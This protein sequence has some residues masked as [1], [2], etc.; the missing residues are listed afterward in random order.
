[1]QESTYPIRFI[2]KKKPIKDVDIEVDIIN[3]AEGLKVVRSGTDKELHWRVGGV[4][5]EELALKMRNELEMGSDVYVIPA[6]RTRS[7]RDK[8]YNL[9][10]MNHPFEEST[11]PSFKRF[12]SEATPD[13]DWEDPFKGEHQWDVDIRSRGHQPSE[14]EKAVSV[15]QHKKWGENKLQNIVNDLR[16][17]IPADY[18]HLNLEYMQTITP[19]REPLHSVTEAEIHFGTKGPWK[20]VLIAHITKEMDEERGKMFWKLDINSGNAGWTYP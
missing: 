13:P 1:M 8:E 3:T 7:G 6:R 5:T 12:F 11:L 16:L 14:E 17:R 2:K 10:I 9:H 19:D 4:N 15:K 20:I 18:K